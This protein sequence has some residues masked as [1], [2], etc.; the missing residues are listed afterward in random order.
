[1][2]PMSEAEMLSIAAERERI[3]RGA[4]GQFFRD[5]LDCHITGV[6]GEAMF[7][8]LCH[9]NYDQMRNPTRGSDGG[10]DFKLIFNQRKTY[11]TFDVKTREDDRWED[12]LVP[13]NKFEVGK[14]AD[15]FVLARCI[16]KKVQF[17]GWEDPKIVKAMPI[18]GKEQKFKCDT[19]V[20]LAEHLRPMSALLRIVALHDDYAR[21]HEA[22]A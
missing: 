15:Y 22:A 2:K 21:F 5:P 9:I 10:Y 3:N 11:L 4:P 6:R 8:Y 19:H 20:R 14:C 17:L 12:L 18:Q 7:A 13:A 16:G 1:M